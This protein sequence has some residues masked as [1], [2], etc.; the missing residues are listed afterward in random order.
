MPLFDDAARTEI[1]ARRQNEG[2][3]EYMN[4][5][6]RPGIAAIRDMLERWFE[7]LPPMAKADVRARFRSSDSAQHESA[8]FELYWHELLCR[9]GYE[10]EVHPT[11]PNAETNPDFLASRNGIALIYVEVTLAMPPGDAAADRRF[12]ELHDTLDRMDSPDYFLHVEYRGSPQGNMRG[13]LIRERLERW[14]RDLD[15]A[16]ITRLYAQQAYDE[17][18][19]LSLTEQGCVLTFTPAPKGPEFR[20]QPGVR[21]V[22]VTMPA[23]GRQLRTQDDIRAAIEGK[24]TKYGELDHPLLV[25]VNVLDDLCHRDDVLSALFGDEQIIAIRREDGSFREEWGRDQNGAWRGRRGPRNEFV[26]AVSITHQLSPS[27]LRSRSVEVIHNPWAE[28][29]LSLDGLLLPQVTFSIP[30]GRMHRHEGTSHAVL[31]EIPEPWPP[32]D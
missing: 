3:F 26:S 28:R 17:V 10:V 14:L 6:A 2:A 5:S 7:R 20:G 32:Q 8:F 19:S 13:R 18:P 15:H 23:E 22:G 30:D 24:G 29:P 21:P 4:T 12:A 11:V 16:E 27:I 9:S 31:L 1:R 25:A